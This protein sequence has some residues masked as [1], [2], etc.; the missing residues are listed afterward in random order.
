MKSL[1]NII[2]TNC[3]NLYLKLKNLWLAILIAC[4][5]LSYPL[6]NSMFHQITIPDAL[7]INMKIIVFSPIAL[8]LFGLSLLFASFN[9]L[10]NEKNYIRKYTTSLIYVFTN[11]FIINVVGLIFVVSLIEAFI[12]FTSLGLWYLT[13]H[14]N[15]LNLLQYLYIVLALFMFAFLDFII[16]LL[17]ISTISTINK[18]GWAKIKV[19]LPIAINELRNAIDFAIKL[20]WL[21]FVFEKLKFAALLCA[22]SLIISGYSDFYNTGFNKFFDLFVLIHLMLVSIMMFVVTKTSRDMH[23]DFKEIFDKFFD[24]LTKYIILLNATLM[25]FVL[26]YFIIL[27]VNSNYNV[28]RIVNSLFDTILFFTVSLFTFNIP[29]MMKEIQKHKL[30]ATIKNK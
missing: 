6:V 1:M 9:T 29:K 15:L 25:L 7:L 11:R 8:I 22:I 23:I 3:I 4:V 5:T 24:Y 27:I 10:L 28:Q 26:T 16:A 12:L 30:K 20:P 21:R 13:E 14:F 19:Q 2:S 17:F 18:Y